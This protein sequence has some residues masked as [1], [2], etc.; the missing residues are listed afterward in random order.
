MKKTNPL[1][2]LDVFAGCGGI[3]LGLVNAGWRG[4]FAIE[5]NPLAFSTLEHNFLKAEKSMFD[6]PSWLPKQAMT[7]EDLLLTYPEQVHS[8]RGSIDLMVGGP[9]C[10]GFSVAGRRDPKDPRNK[11]TEQ[12]LALVGLVAPRFLVIENVAGFDIRFGSNGKSRPSN[13]GSYAMYVM[14]RLRKL[15]YRVS[16]GLVNCAEFGVP[17]NRFRYLII[18]ELEN[19]SGVA[20][21]LV[22]TLTQFS[23]KF[24]ISKGLPVNRYVGT[25]EAIGDLTIANKTR[26][27]YSSSGPPGYYE[28][29]YEPPRNPTPYQTLMRKGMGAVAPNSRRLPK[30]R[31]E[32]I[33]AFEMFQKTCRPGVKASDAER[34]IL[35]MSKHTRTMLHPKLPSPTVTTLPDDIL[36]YSEPR[37]LTVRENARLQSFPDWFSFQGKYTT[38]GEKRKSETPRYSQVGNAVPPLLSEA[39]GRILAERYK[40]LEKQANASTGKKLFIRQ[41]RSVCT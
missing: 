16:N 31:T 20:V 29:V 35:G 37:I 24:R 25:A 5:K 26:V 7:A 34:K 15:G 30:H 9:P 14:E 10:Q 19:T 6:W 28:A 39:I 11:L 23:A 13:E 32:T 18:C 33:A 36:H 17:Q 21:D 12:Y 8:L 22:K 41:K 27:P 40:T 4:V 3:S 38:G 1:R 2:F